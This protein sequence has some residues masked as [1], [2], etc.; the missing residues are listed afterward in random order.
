MDPWDLSNQITAYLKRQG[1]KLN[2]RHRREIERKLKS[3]V[4]AC[5]D[6]TQKPSSDPDMVTYTPEVFNLVKGEIAA[7]R[8][9]N[10]RPDTKWDPGEDSALKKIFPFSRRSFVLV[11]KYYNAAPGKNDRDEEGNRLR[12][13]LPKEDVRKWRRTSIATFLN[14]FGRE[15]DKAQEFADQMKVAVK[16]ETEKPKKKDWSKI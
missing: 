4:K 15:I 3:A 13:A 16:A 1:F 10:R 2:D 11:K 7:F 8:Y 12:D 14:N 5:E 6:A 9:F